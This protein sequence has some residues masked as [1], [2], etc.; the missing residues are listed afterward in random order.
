M[1]SL[2]F[3]HFTNGLPADVALGQ[4]I[5]LL[6]EDAVLP[7]NEGERYAKPAN[8]QNVR[9]AA[10]KSADA[11]RMLVVDVET[12][13][14][15]P[16]G[17]DNETANQYAIDRFC[18][19]LGWIKSERS[20]LKV[21]IYGVPFGTAGQNLLYQQKAGTELPT[22][23]YNNIR[24]MW[25]RPE[26]QMP[27]PGRLLNLID[28]ICPVLYPESA[29]SN[30]NVAPLGYSDADWWTMN[31]DLLR[32]SWKMWGKPVYVFLSPHYW[33]QHTNGLI[34][35]E[36]AA[37]MTRWCKAKGHNRIWW[38]TWQAGEWAAGAR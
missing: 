13:W 27:K 11:G 37:A 28:F 24:W 23:A 17:T 15:P 3:H 5:D 9:A 34:T 26:G 29:S 6:Y 30:P 8:E 12:W 22:M 19:V 7:Y 4:P 1:A 38:G 25:D 14:A 10:R 16:E 31:A 2:L 32:P 21:G 33:G 36:L 20:S 35:R 18:E